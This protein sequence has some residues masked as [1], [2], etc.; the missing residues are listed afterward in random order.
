MGAE[1]GGGREAE[2]AQRLRALRGHDREEGAER[3]CPQE[4]REGLGINRCRDAS[5]LMPPA[6]LAGS[7][8]RSP[9][10]GPELGGAVKSSEGALARTAFSSHVVCLLCCLCTLTMPHDVVHL[11]CN[12]VSLDIRAALR[13]FLNA[14]TPP[15][16]P[17]G[18]I[19]HRNMESRYIPRPS[20]QGSS[21]SN[22]ERKSVS[23]VTTQPR[24]TNLRACAKP[25]QGPFKSSAPRSSM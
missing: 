10:A 24:R 16:N 9:G 20:E 17:C 19:M 2:E 1:A 12:S 14:C 22:G 6:V 13:F 18:G 5:L 8:V 4:R 21:Y 25:K 23:Y 3:R 7:R 15:R 11:L